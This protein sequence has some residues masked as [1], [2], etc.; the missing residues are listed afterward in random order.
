MADKKLR[1]MF[2]R[3]LT[4]HFRLLNKYQ[5]ILIATQ[6]DIEA[7]QSISFS[8]EIC[9]AIYCIKHNLA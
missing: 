6:E 7:S 4:L 3:E 2:G 8:S 1:E 9:D 5:I